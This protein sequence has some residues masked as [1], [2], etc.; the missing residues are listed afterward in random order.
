M[1]Y[2]LR[3]S[4]NKTFILRQDSS[5]RIIRNRRTKKP[6]DVGD[7]II[8]LEGANTFGDICKHVWICSDLLK[9]IE[10]GKELPRLYGLELQISRWMID[11]DGKRLSRRR[12]EE[13]YGI[14]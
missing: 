4:I 11:K 1:N 12:I 13:L 10:K 6:F 3:E 14:K 7:E 5:G 2:I 8:F 9:L